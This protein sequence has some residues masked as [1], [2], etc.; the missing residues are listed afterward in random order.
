MYSGLFSYV[1]HLLSETQN[2]NYLNWTHINYQMKDIKKAKYRQWTV[3]NY[4][5]EN[6][7]VFTKTKRWNW[8]TFTDTYHTRDH[9]GS[10]VSYVQHRL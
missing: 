5:D 3:T 6:I 2:S 9:L 1:M 8:P 4:D 10:S 7:P